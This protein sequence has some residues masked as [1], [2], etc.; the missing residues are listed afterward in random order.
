MQKLAALTRVSHQSASQHVEFLC[1]AFVDMINKGQWIL[2][3]ARLLMDARN[4]CITPLGVV[5]QRDHYPQ[6]ICDYYFYLVN[7]D[8][9]EFCPEESMQFGRAL[10]RILQQISR[11]D[12][13]L[14]PVYLSKIDI[15]DGFYR[16]AIR[17]DDIPKLAIKFPTRVEKSN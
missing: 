14:G 3:L 16:I 12:P 7:P 8:T 10:L 15:T 1:G 17:L 9:I 4:L 5:P 6:A 13:R 2:F 11:S